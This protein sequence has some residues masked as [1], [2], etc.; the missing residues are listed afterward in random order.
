MTGSDLREQISQLESDIERL[1]DSVERCRKIA[2]AAKV[3]IGAGCVL[4]A[5]LLVGPLG[6]L[7]GLFSVFKPV[8][9]IGVR[10]ALARQ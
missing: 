2:V 10:P 3:V 9:K 7:V 6:P 5:S 8:Q 4:F 1:S